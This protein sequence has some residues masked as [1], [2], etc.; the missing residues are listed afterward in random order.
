MSGNKKVILVLCVLAVSLGGML[1]FNTL[2]WMTHRC[3]PPTWCFCWGEKPF[4][5]MPF[6]YAYFFGGVFPLWFS[7]FATGVV[8]T[9]VVCSAAFRRIFSLN[10]K[11][12]G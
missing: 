8:I 6:W 10:T 4:L 1:G 5:C 7:G 11:N 12:E 3:P 9:V 2:D